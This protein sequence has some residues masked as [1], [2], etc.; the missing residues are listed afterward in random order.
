MVGE[1]KNICVI[2][3]W[4]EHCQKKFSLPVGGSCSE[5]TRD[6]RI[7]AEREEE[8]DKDARKG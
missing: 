4:R 8:K 2:C 5:F 3:A 6:V 7:K 1:G